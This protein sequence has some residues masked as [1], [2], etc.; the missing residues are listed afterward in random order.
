MTSVLTTTGRR[1]VLRHRQFRYLWL[2]QS[3]SALG[4]PVFPF[5]VAFLAIGRGEGVASVALVLAAR[6]LGTSCAVLVGGVLADRF[7]RTR[8]M[9]SADVVRVAALAAMVVVGD[10][11]PLPVVSALVFV[12]GVGEAVFRPAYGAVV[13]SLVPSE[14]VQAA[15]ALTALVRRFAGFVGP[16]AASVLVVGLSPRGALAVDAAT[17]LAS[18]GSLL[19]VRE[20][21]AAREPADG[22]PRTGFGRDVRDGFRT[23]LARRWLA[24]EIGVGAIQVACCLAPW[25]VLL[26]VVA[27]RSLGGPGRYA[28]VLVAMSAGALVGAFVGGRVRVS[29]PGVVASLALLPFSAALLGLALS[30]PFAFVVALHVL[31]G[32][33]TEIYLVLW[34]TAIQRGVPADQLGRVF[35]IDQLGSLALL[36]LAMAAT[37]AVSDLAGIAATLVVAAL[38]NAATSVL[39]LFLADV[40]R[41]GESEEQPS[42]P[43]VRAESPR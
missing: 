11:T 29:R 8:I 17:F 5:A 37:G 21:A 3:L 10:R 31:A 9:L 19:V 20:P 41:F 32:L 1:S 43:D 30:W 33:G 22:G 12:V 18:I 36:P 14:D 7:R 42:G 15:N 39:P 40:R 34:Y 23:V 27:N 35:A 38:I 28:A 25:L 16:A 6:A 24:L 4:D 2:G 26:P 13:P